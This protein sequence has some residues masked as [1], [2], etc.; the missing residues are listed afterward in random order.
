[1]SAPTIEREA[2]LPPFAPKYTHAA[3]T[4]SDSDGPMIE[5]EHDLM[6]D[7]KVQSILSTLTPAAARV[8]AIQGRHVSDRMAA[9]WAADQVTIANYQAAAADFARHL[10][11]APRSDGYIPRSPRETSAPLAAPRQ[12][13][14]NARSAA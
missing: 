13:E 12:S 14:T 5:P 9:K 1:M 6:I 2:D 10:R 8:M 4:W 3:R 7:L 11:V